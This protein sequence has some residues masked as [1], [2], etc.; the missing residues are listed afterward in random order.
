MLG[1]LLGGLGFGRWDGECLGFEIED[2]SVIRILFD[3]CEFL[4]CVGIGV[5]VVTYGG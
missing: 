4:G 3:F 2:F 1:G 5:V